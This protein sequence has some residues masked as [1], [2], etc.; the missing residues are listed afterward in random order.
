LLKRSPTIPSQPPVSALSL[1]LSDRD[2]QECEALLKRAIEMVRLPP[3]SGPTKG[4]L[5]AMP[6]GQVQLHY[7]RD[8]AVYV[9]INTKSGLSLLRHRD[10]AR[11]RAMCDR[12]GWQVVASD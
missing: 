10:I 9:A 3:R 4:L 5:D 12:L 11:L 8:E 7:D 6:S 2:A 1:A